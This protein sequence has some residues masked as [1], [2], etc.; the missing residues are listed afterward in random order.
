MVD[1][2]YC[3]NLERRPDRLAEA[4]AEF[5]REDIGEVEIFRATDGRADAPEGIRISKPEWGCSDSHIRIWRDVVQNGYECALVFEDDVKIL[6]NFNYKLEQVLEDLKSVPDW[7]YVNLGPLSWRIERGTVSP[8]LSRGSAYGAH[9]YL[10]SLRGARKISIWETDD[11]QF[12]QDCQLARSPL[13]MYY[14]PEPLANQYSTNTKYLEI[15]QSCMTGDICF[16]R[17]ADFDFLIR[18]SWQSSLFV[19]IFMILLFFLIRRLIRN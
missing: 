5:N 2:I 19:L 1:H 14:C 10:V 4:R 3:I 8:R 11:L 7:D 17:T 15:I 12:C 16:E 18:S 6:P 9:C 13:K